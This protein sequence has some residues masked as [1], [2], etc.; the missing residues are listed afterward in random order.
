MARK[1]DVEA[2]EYGRV[3]DPDDKRE[4]TGT[5][6]KKK[7]KRATDDKA[8]KLK[9]LAEEPK[10]KRKKRTVEEP[11][12]VKRVKKIDQPATS[13]QMA[14]IEKKRARVEQELQTLEVMPVMD[15][16]DLQYRHMFNRLRT[17]TEAFEI[18]MEDN[19]S[20][21][22]VYAL[23]T[24][25]SQMR[26]VIADMRSTKDVESQMAELESRAYEGFL[27]AVGQG[28]V[29]LLFTVTRDIRKNVKDRDVQEQLI[30]TLNGS[31][32]DQSDTVMTSYRQ[33]IDNVRTVLM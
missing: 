28:Y 32:K 16:F 7:K 3:K 15:E 17:I 25:Y 11:T 6:T 18:Q 10:K 1:K 12:S 27:R 26:E 23:S 30:A 22:D 19:P 13:K 4:R 8:E 29:T 21:R 31:A 2:D 9:A 33:M 14:R 24:L 20:G 5:G